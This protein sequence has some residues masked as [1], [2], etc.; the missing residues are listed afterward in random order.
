[1][2]TIAVFCGSSTGIR[3]EYAGA[4]TALGRAIADRGMTLVYGGASVGLMGMLADAAIS[5]GG[6][7]VGVIPEALR[8]K[9]IDHGGLAELHVVDS[10]HTRKRM[11]AD[12]ADA[13][14]ALPGGIGTFEELFEVWTWAM[15]GHHE[16]PCALL[17]VASYYDRLIGFL[18]HVSAEGFVRAEHRAMLLVDTEPARLLDR[19]ASYHP[20]KVAKWID[21]QQT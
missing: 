7:V 16:K 1:M 17:D 2:E 6:S 21:E 15:L 19:L 18:D 8:R 14:V 4:A 5:A 9:E 13:F 11:M 10:M 12:R 20:P 3:P